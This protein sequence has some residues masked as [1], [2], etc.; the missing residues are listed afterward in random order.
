MDHINM[1]H[2]NSL[3]KQSPRKEE[4]PSSPIS[5]YTKSFGSALS[6]QMTELIPSKS[7]TQNIQKHKNVTPRFHDFRTKFVVR[8][9]NKR[10][11]ET[12]AKTGK[13]GYVGST[14]IG[15]RPSDPTSFRQEVRLLY[16][17]I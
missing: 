17:F 4:E 1:R 11:A 15:D 14:A 9:R 6:A 3:R 12:I 5:Q 8:T 13:R 16:T 10:Q 2:Y 7:R